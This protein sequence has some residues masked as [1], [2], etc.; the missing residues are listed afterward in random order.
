MRGRC[1]SDHMVRESFLS[2]GRWTRIRHRKYIDR[3][4]L[5]RRRIGTRQGQNHLNCVHEAVNQRQMIQN[6]GTKHAERS[7]RRFAWISKYYELL[8][9][10]FTPSGGSKIRK[11]PF[12][13]KWKDLFPWNLAG[14][15]GRTFGQTLG[16]EDSRG[17]Y[18]R[19]LYDSAKFLSQ[20]SENVIF[21]KKNRWNPTT[22]KCILVLFKHFCFKFE[23]FFRQ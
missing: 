19:L 11:Y 7:F 21:E 13:W 6:G 5:E 4:G 10:F 9:R 16:T 2:P 23:G 22:E 18:R 8:I 20:K 15:F 1:V 12:L 3:Q 17:K 14:C